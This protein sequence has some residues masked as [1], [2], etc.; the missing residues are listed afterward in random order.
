MILLPF[1]FKMYDTIRQ[2]INA[3]GIVRFKTN[4]FADTH[5]DFYVKVGIFQSSKYGARYKVQG[6]MHLNHT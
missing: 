6:A 2:A 4:V 5:T 1:G 3:K